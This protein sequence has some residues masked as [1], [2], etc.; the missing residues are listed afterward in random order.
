MLSNENTESEGRAIVEGEYKDADIQ[1]PVSVGSKEV[2]KHQRW[3]AFSGE[4]ISVPLK[5]TDAFKIP[6]QLNMLPET[7]LQTDV[8]Y[9]SMIHLS[10]TMT[11]T[12]RLLLHQ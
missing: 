10:I 5:L 7:I 1:I 4:T 2:P 9:S 8:F 3:A 6:S 12:H 11:S